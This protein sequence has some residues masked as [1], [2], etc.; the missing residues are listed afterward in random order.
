MVRGVLVLEFKH[1][2]DG[3]KRLNL[4]LTRTP[5]LLY[6]ILHLQELLQGTRQH[7]AGVKIWDF[8]L[9]TYF[10]STNSDWKLI[11]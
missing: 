4:L 3:L 10:C 6:L 5:V 7:M 9:K 8:Q 1:A 11:R 2:S